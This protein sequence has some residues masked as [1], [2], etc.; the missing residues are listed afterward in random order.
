MR[1]SSSV[2]SRSLFSSLPVAFLLAHASLPARAD[3]TSPQPPQQEITSPQL[4]SPF[5]AQETT[6]A[7]PQAAPDSSFETPPILQASAILKAPYF[8]GPYHT[9]APQVPTRGGRNFYQLQS[10]FGNFQAEGSF[11]LMERVAELHAIAK[12]REIS[13]GEEYKKALKAAAKSPVELARHLA[14]DP[15]QTVTDIPRGV[16]KFVKRT[17][18]TISHA[19]KKEGP[20]EHR[21]G[22]DSGFK[23]ILG[24]S[25]VKRELADALNVDPYSPNEVLQ[26]ELDRIAKASVA[27][28]MTFSL[29][30]LP[31]GGAA[32]DA[33][34][35]VG[36]AQSSSRVLKESTP[37]ELYQH[38]LK[39]L[40]GMG[41]G[42]KRA[43]AFLDHP[44]YTATLQVT[45]VDALQRLSNV[46]G[47]ERYL[48]AALEANTRGD[49]VFFT[50]SARLMAV[51]HQK[52][53]LS[54]IDVIAGLPI[55][56]QANG[57][58]LVPLEWD[59]ACWTRNT[60]SFVRQVKTISERGGKLTGY[61]LVI[62]GAA[63][64]LL[65]E[66]LAAK[67]VKLTEFAVPGPLKGS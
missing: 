40:A 6:G 27:G 33:L 28:K 30:T 48:L 44:Y 19:V 56:K 57:V 50:R 42:E 14:D 29:G 54:H 11:E 4:L 41:I 24:I 22:E 36:L 60:E 15:V 39:A 49:A 63:S 7:T 31:I 17:K 45:L 47:R 37:A 34:L 65:K 20:E 61:R 16:F 21:P 62:T 1:L 38:L 67:N 25:K 66:K 2:L 10:T 5:Y 9:V 8:Q 55:C 46:D 12:L 52:T 53:A 51:L 58:L 23:Q 59:Y 32:G 43:R 3:L 13:E 26:D 18:Q 64:P 35:G